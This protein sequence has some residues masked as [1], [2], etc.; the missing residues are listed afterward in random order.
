MLEFKSTQQR[1]FYWIQ[2]TEKDKDDEYVKKVNTSLNGE[3][4]VAAATAPTTQA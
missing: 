3:P 1:H 4:T 2:E